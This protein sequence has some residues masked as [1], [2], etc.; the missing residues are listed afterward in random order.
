MPQNIG[1]DHFGVK[2]W[3][4]ES[5]F[6]VVEAI[7]KDFRRLFFENIHL[8]IENDQLKAELREKD[9]ELAELQRVVDVSIAGLDPARG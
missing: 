6:T 2:A 4:D 7:S 1:F 8:G 9:E 5:Q 3:F